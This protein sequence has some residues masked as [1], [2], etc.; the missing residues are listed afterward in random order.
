MLK[1]FLV[2][3]LL[4]GSLIQSISDGSTLCLVPMSTGFLSVGTQYQQSMFEFFLIYA[5]LL[6]TNS[7]KVSESH[8]NIPRTQEESVKKQT[9]ENWNLK[10][11]CT[12]LASLVAK[13]DPISSILGIVIFSALV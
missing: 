4:T 9:S 12:F 2:G 6:P 11:S 10:V 1:V 3:H 7:L 5:T 13:R 8:C